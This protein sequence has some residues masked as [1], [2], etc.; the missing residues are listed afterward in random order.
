MAPHSPQPDEAPQAI[1]SMESSIED[2]QDQDGV[3][4]EKG[5][6]IDL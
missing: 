4:E 5:N 3:A 2:Y 6:Q 1:R